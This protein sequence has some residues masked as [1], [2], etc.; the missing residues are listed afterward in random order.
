MVKPSPKF[1][2]RLVIVPVEVS[3]NVTVRGSNPAVGF[4]VKAPIGI[5]APIPV[6]E[7]DRLGPLLAKKVTWLVNGPT[8][9]GVNRTETF[10]ELNAGRVNAKGDCKL[11]GP[12][13]MLRATL[14]IGPPPPLVATKTA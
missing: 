7:L 14:V 4:A 3:E 10:V 11:K 1:Q 13:L 12:L 9:T 5:C 8:L 2:E 6:T